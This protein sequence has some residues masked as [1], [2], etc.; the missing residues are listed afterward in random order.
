MAAV[1]VV[2]A[3]DALAK[4]ARYDD[5]DFEWSAKLARG[6]TVE[7]H[8]VNGA[9]QAGPASGREVEVTAVKRAKRSDPSDVKIEVVEHDGGITICAVY[10]GPGN[11][12]E[13]GSSH[14]HTRN[15]DVV[16]DFTV[17]VPAGIKLVA[18]TVTGGIEAEDLDGPV[19]ATTVNGSVSVSTEGTA[20]ATTVN[21]S[22]SARVGSSSWDDELKFSTVNGGITVRFPEDLNADVD[23]STLNGNIQTDFP[24]TVRGKM[25]RRHITG[26]IGHGGGGDLSLTTVNGSIRLVSLGD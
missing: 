6:Q 10:P 21:G 8:G 11:S 26:R 18:N 4:S 1:L 14:S 13:P 25:G 3:S 22:V 23:A 15:N 5:P 9:I 20:I 19:E 7:I 24:L 2:P 16:V 12:C 17:R